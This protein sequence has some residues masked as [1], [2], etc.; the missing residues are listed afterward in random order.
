VQEIDVSLPELMFRLE[1]MLRAGRLPKPLLSCATQKAFDAA[2]GLAFKRTK[3]VFHAEQPSS[4]Q[5]KDLQPV[6]LGKSSDD[7]RSGP[8]TPRLVVKNKPHEQS[9]GYEITNVGI[10]LA[11]RYP[12]VRH[13]RVLSNP[14]GEVH[15]LGRRISPQTTSLVTLARISSRFFAFDVSIHVRIYRKSSASPPS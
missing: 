8:P 13:T 9:L 15:A 14:G 1:S 4:T 6:S 5:A 10:A 11:R 7:R 2:A 12:S 3:D